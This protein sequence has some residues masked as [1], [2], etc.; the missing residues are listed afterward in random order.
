MVATSKQPEDDDGESSS[1][2]D[3]GHN[4]GDSNPDY[5][6]KKEVMG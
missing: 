4:V 3:S 1:G 5:S 6:P 2:E